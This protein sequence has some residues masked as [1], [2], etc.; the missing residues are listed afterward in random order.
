LYVVRFVR[1]HESSEDM[2][3]SEVD[4]SSLAVF[5]KE[6]HYP[7]PSWR[8]LGRASKARREFQNYA[9]FA[10]IGIQ[11]AERVA[12]GERRDLIRRLHSAFIITRAIPDVITLTEFFKQHGSRDV[13]GSTAL[14]AQLLS[15]LA[16]MTKR[17]HAANFFHNDLYWRN[18]L[19]TWV[20]P[21]ARLWW[22][23]CPRGGFKRRAFWPN[24]K[25]IKDL[26]S[27]DKIAAQLCTPKERIEFVKRYLNIQRLTEIAK[28]LVRATLAYRRK[29]WPED[30]H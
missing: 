20:P 7:K 4:N 15:Q 17:I 26:A 18:V 5:F 19:V 9:A 1:L 28:H 27:L 8:F 14:R 25:Q 21:E 30:W 11:A 10:K 13:P 16:F 12:Y 6:Y 29:R 24:R 3:R 23:D 22:I 2:S